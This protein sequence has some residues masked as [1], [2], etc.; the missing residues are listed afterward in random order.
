MIVE[1]IVFQT[2][3]GKGDELVALMKQMMK[4]APADLT[5]RSP[6]LLTDRSGTFFTVVAE[7][8]WENFAEW[9]KAF[10]RMFSDAKFQSLMERT[11]ALIESG[12]REFYNLE[13]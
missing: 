13:M 1:R 3:Y 8:E 9:E 7:F 2:K 11:T 12:R 10:G 6:R 5:G 4:E